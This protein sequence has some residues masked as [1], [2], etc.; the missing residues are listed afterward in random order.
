MKD[1]QTQDCKECE[2]LKSFSA[3]GKAKEICPKCYKKTEIY[4]RKEGRFIVNHCSLCHEFF[5]EDHP[6]DISAYRQ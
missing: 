6:T 3:D 5:M 4:Y 1:N 2:R